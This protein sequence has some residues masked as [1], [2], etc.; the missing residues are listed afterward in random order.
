MCIILAKQHNYSLL[1]INQS[2][3]F[4]A[5]KSELKKCGFNSTVLSRMSHRFVLRIARISVMHD[6]LNKQGACFLFTLYE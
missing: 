2:V 5:K 4:S 6:Q 3:T 1:T